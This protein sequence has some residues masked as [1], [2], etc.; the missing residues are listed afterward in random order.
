VHS[1][2]TMN[3]EIKRMLEDQKL[4]VICTLTKDKTPHIISVKDKWLVGDDKILFGVWQMYVTE[5][6]IKNNS[7]V[8]LYLVDYKKAKA[9]QIEGK[10]EFIE[11]SDVK[12]IIPGELPKDLI[13]LYPYL[14]KLLLVHVNRIFY[15]QYG[16]RTNQEYIPTQKPIEVPRI[17]PPFVPSNF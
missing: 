16:E 3:N 1:M 5:A 14:R 10:G 11:K 2:V 9:F 12:N 6:N 4:I 8:Y 7:P 15:R 13:K 17:I